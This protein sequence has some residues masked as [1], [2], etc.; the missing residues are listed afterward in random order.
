[1][2][3]FFVLVKKLLFKKCLWTKPNSRNFN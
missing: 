3:R 1:M 2:K